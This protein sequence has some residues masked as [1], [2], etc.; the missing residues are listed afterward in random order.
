MHH[1]AKTVLIQVRQICT[2]NTGKVCPIE[3]NTNLSSILFNK[4]FKNIF[5]FLN[6]ILPDY[7]FHESLKEF[8]QNSHFENMRAEF[9][10]VVKNHFGK[11]ALK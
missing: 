10:K 1:C 9:L 6:C 11:L 7:V 5:Y 4:K 2:K 8:W 3:N